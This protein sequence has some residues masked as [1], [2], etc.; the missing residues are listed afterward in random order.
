M[1]RLLHF[2][3][4]SAALPM[5]A[6]S[7]SS[8]V[9]TK[10][11]LFIGNSLTAAY[12][13]PALVEAFSNLNHTVKLTTEAVVMPGTNL[14][15]Q[16]NAGHAAK[17]IR[18]GHWDYVVLQQGPTARLEDRGNLVQY[19]KK[20]ANE[21]RHSGAAIAMYMVWP[22]KSETDHFTN[23]AGA[24]RAAAQETHGAFIPAGNAWKFL[25][26]RKH[27]DALYGDDDFH[28]SPRGAVLSALVIHNVLCACRL[29]RLPTKLVFPDGPQIEINDPQQLIDAA[30]A[31]ITAAQAKEK[32]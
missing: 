18:D 5:A 13:I 7:S 16:W 10:R 15:D 2:L 14:E 29:D 30:D 32:K 8:S 23:I 4:L 6:Q 26:D 24:F 25:L 21:A 27:G 22:G 9:P 3:I 1:P 11:V 31:A 28:P 19:A 12:N 17:K 20:F